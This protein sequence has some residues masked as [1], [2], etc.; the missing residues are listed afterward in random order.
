[1]FAAAIVWFQFFVCAV[2]IAIAGTRLSRYGDVIADKT[3]LGGS[4]IGLV[5]MASVT[6]LP[7]LVTGVSSVTFAGV[8]DIAVGNVLGACII[9]LTMIVFLDLLH[10]EESV[11]SRA[12]QGH[13]LS[14]GYGVILIG[15][16]G[17]NVLFAQR[18]DAFTL[19]YIGL[20]T[21]IIALL[22]LIA[23]RTVFTYER[24]RRAQL[25][26]DRVER[27]PD[28]SLRHALRQYVL[29]GLVVVAVGIWLPYVGQDLARVMGW[30]QTFVG[31]LFIAFATTLPEIVVTVSALRLGALDM[32]ISNLLGSNLF[33]ILILAVD[34]LLYFQGPLLSHVSS[35]H[36]VS[37]ISATMMSGVAIVGLFYRPKARLFKTVGWTSLLLLSIY[38]L[39]VFF[40]YLYSE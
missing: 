5:L 40:L 17:F 29:A 35:L 6:S 20:Y 4:W 21:P 33:N 30:E 37:A 13:I 26:E 23:M 10:R 24:N 18:G 32:A 22:Y 28:I 11:Y 2:L 1:M 8:P 27:Y 25:V 7:E 38:L 39:N 3:G 19:G 12:S 31:T 34:D 14:A 16:V 9:N 15:F 36:A